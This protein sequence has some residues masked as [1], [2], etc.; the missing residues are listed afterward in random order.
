MIIDQLFTSK[1]LEEG[2]PYDLPGKDYAR[3]GDTP[4]KRPSGEHNPYPYSPEE[5]DDYFRE[6]FRKKREAAAKEQEVEED[7][8]RR[9]FMQGLGMAAAG[10]AGLGAATDAQARAT[11][12]W[13]AKVERA[14]TL[15]A[16][17]QSREQTAR[18]M[19]IKGPNPGGTGQMFGDWGAV[20]SAAQEMRVK[21]ST[22]RKQRRLN[23]TLLM[24]DPV[25]RNFKRVGRYISEQK[26]TEPEIL[27][28]F[29]NAETGMTDKGTGANRTFLGRGKDT[30]MDFAGSV[31]DALKGVWGGIQNSVT[32]QA[33][34]TAWD[35]ATD[36][37]ANLTGGQKGA[38][39]T[40]INKYR[41]LAKQY[42]KT[43][44][45]A[46]AALVAIA[47]LA[48]GGAGLPA[49]AAVFLPDGIGN[50]NSAPS[51][52]CSNLPAMNS[53]TTLTQ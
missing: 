51:S 42:P 10:A 5:D 41:N 14:K 15:M 36:A 38:V 40:A 22:N 18:I 44:G 31:A 52:V 2:G 39:M 43:A 24:E 37:M 16:K 32:V 25:Y 47:G 34:D 12:E 23:E 29:S 17:G 33:V 26:L 46:K 28:I 21:E 49:V 3:P 50:I 7:L 19:G 53:L 11:P 4:R 48:T 6:I 35:Q 45:L 9:G 13:T 1:P 8:N 30:T 20:N 27:Q